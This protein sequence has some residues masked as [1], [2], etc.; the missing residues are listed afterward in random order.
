MLQETLSNLNCIQFFH[1]PLGPLG[2]KSAQDSPMTRPSVESS[3][4]IFLSGEWKLV[5]LPRKSG[6]AVPDIALQAG[7]GESVLYCQPTGSSPP[8]RLDDLVDRPCAMEVLNSL[9]HAA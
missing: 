5:T 3:E 7:C 8:H 2:F 1:G 6:A 9:F 4:S